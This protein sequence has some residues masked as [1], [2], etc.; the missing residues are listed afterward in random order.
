MRSKFF[1]QFINRSLIELGI[2]DYKEAKTSN[3]AIRKAAAIKEIERTGDKAAT[4][5]F[6]CHNRI[7]IVD[8]YTHSK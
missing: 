6:L 3:H 5:K 4:S 2:D 1:S 7:N 8:T